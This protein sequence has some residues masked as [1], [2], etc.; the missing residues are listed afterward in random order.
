M[1][2]GGVGGQGHEQVDYVPEKR[3]PTKVELLKD[4]KG[5]LK[6]TR[7]GLKTLE[8]I[9]QRQVDKLSRVA[10][11]HGK[12]IS[13]INSKESSFISKICGVFKA[14]TSFIGVKNAQR[15]LK[16]SEKKI[17]ADEADIKKLDGKKVGLEK[18]I[19]KDNNAVVQEIKDHKNS[20][21][22]SPD[23]LSPEEK[24]DLEEKIKE[25]ESLPED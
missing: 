2:I 7:A 24:K 11:L 8:H 19:K 18:G 15:A 25:L 22:N 6:E 13:Q 17:R 3:V 21:L 12:A 10:D 4:V 23:D 5:S 20:T 14:F 16:G 9:K 1:P